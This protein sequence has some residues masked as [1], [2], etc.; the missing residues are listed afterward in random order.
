MIINATYTGVRKA[1]E[2]LCRLEKAEAFL[3]AVNGATEREHIINTELDALVITAEETRAILQRRIDGIRDNL[4][5]LGCFPDP[6]DRTPE[7][8]EPAYPDIKKECK[9]T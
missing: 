7:L 6:V 4:R 1:Y 5:D 9:C 2:L 8:A 3:A